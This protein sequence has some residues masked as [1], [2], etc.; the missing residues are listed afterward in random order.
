M[1]GRSSFPFDGMVA[2]GKQPGRQFA[3]LVT[4]I[5]PIAGKWHEHFSNYYFANQR[6]Q[7]RSIMKVILSDAMNP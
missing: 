4:K 2:S 1:S 7:F 6:D 3:V 5:T